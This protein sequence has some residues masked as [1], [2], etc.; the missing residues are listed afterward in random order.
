MLPSLCLHWNVKDKSCQM[1]K[2]IFNV[3]VLET[4]KEFR[5]YDLK[6]STCKNEGYYTKKPEVKEFRK[7]KEGVL[8]PKKPD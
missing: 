3:E 4:A 1:T 5:D 6:M 2:C 7:E 8:W